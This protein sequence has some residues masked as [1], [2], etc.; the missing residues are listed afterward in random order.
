MEVQF[1]NTIEAD[2]MRRDVIARS[3]EWEQRAQSIAN[4]RARKNEENAAKGAA[5]EERRKIAENVTLQCLIIFQ[6]CSL[7]SLKGFMCCI[8]AF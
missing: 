6:R 7:N 1:I 3:Q 2:N 5:A 4:E 8:Y